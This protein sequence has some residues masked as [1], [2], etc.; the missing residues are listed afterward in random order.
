EYILKVG[1]KFS[2]PSIR[3]EHITPKIIQLL[4]KCGVRT[5]TI[6]PETGT[7]SLRYNL[8]KKIS[9]DK[10]LDVL[11]LIKESGIK[12]VKFYFLIGLPNES[13]EDIEGIIRFFQLIEKIG[14]KHNELRV[15][16]NPFI[17]KLN[18]PYE[19]QCYYYL[20]ENLNNFRLKFNTLKQELNKIS[21]IKI[22]FKEPKRIINNARLQALFSL[23]DR[24]ISNL[25]IAY[26]FNGANMGALR[27]AEKDLDFSI[28]NYFK[29]IQDGYK[30]WNF[31]NK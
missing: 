6:A 3:I 17:P 9:N 23:G 11:S 13:D 7:E 18:T 5:I 20:S 30:P 10:I 15:N 24:N 28:D 8:G 26:Y 22:K 12:N 4:E 31:S 25:L 29:K 2:I 21:S 19:N 14:F 1:K 27:R 16:I